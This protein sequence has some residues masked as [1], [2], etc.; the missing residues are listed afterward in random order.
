MFV[1]NEDFN[2]RIIDLFMSK[3]ADPK[4][5][6]INK[7]SIIFYIAKDNKIKLLAKVLKFGFNLNDNDYMNQTP[8]F[9]TAK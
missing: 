4:D 3:G 5:K 7:Q 1:P 9:Y 2:L 8:L 6:E